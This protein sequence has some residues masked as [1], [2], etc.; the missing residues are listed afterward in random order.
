MFQ[1]VAPIS[2]ELALSAI[3][4]VT[5]QQCAP[6]FFSRQNPRYNDFTRLLR[7]LAYES[8]LF[9]RAVSL[10]CRFALTE[11]PDEKYDSIRALLKSLFHIYLSGTQATPEQR[12]EIIKQLVNT[13]DP[14][15]AELAMLLL[16]A[17][18]QSFHFS[19]VYG[20]EFGA[21][22]RDYGYS[23]NTV[24]E[25]KH[26]YTLFFEYAEEIALSSS[27]LAPKARIVLADNFRG[28]WLHSW[29]FD[30]L[31][32]MARKLSA[33]ESWPEGWLAIHTTIRLDHEDMETALLSRLKRLA[34]DLMPTSLLDLIKLYALSD[35]RD[36]RDLID[37]FLDDENDFASASVA[38]A[39]HVKSL[40]AQLTIADTVLNEILPQLLSA[41]KSSRLFDLG[42]GLA[43]ATTKPMEMWRKLYSGVAQIEETERCYNLLCGFL[44]SLSQCDKNICEAILNSAVDDEILSSA[45]P[46]L[47]TSVPVDEHG[48]RRLHAALALGKAPIWL[49]TYLAWG[50]RH[51]TINDSD[52]CDLLRSIAAI[53]GGDDVAIEILMMRLYGESKNSISSA[54][55][56]LG[57]EL[58]LHYNYCRKQDNTSD[59]TDWH[60]ST[61]I[62]S[63]FKGKSS[64]LKAKTICQKII[65][66]FE[67]NKI[68][69]FHDYHSVLDALAEI[70]PMAVLDMIV[71]IIPK[72][73]WL[74]N[75]DIYSPISKIDPDAIIHWCKRKPNNRFSTISSIIQPF[76]SNKA[77]HDLQWSPIAVRLIAEAPDPISVL[78]NF[79]PEF[80][81]VGG[82]RG[83]QSGEMQRRANLLAELKKNSNSTIADWAVQEEN[84]LVKE[85]QEMR[86]IEARQINDQDERFE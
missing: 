63:C 12:L 78:N 81:P 77:T 7:L 17:A 59:H 2:P 85:I 84:I 67:K 32:S 80:R 44:N 13:G 55:I 57:Q 50:R 47:Q 42:Q 52:L 46:L 86:R 73:R 21:R 70:Q 38:L 83:T 45:F 26:W 34:A 43:E 40:G 66:A 62:R 16:E 56:S 82:W 49:Y 22:V 54:I 25:I 48:V 11:Q 18:L 72:Y 6:I 14:K 9:T 68:Y 24:E 15:K 20:F 76:Q 58:A 3:E 35:G 23:P 19:S 10:I 27:P 30:E 60:L 36:S 79:K 28:L 1:N 31:E 75:E 69:S 51:E 33:Q 41:K 61:I 4:R 65:Q 29:A 37:I 64:T 8:E 74:S 71:S 5:S 53:P 39:N